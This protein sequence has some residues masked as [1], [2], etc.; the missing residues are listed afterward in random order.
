MYSDINVS[1]KKRGGG[2]IYVLVILGSY[3]MDNH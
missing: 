3:S 2:L 1:F